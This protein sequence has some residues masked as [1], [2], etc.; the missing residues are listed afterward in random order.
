MISIMYFAGHFVPHDGLRVLS[1]FDF[2][3]FSDIVCL[4]KWKGEFACVFYGKDL[5]LPLFIAQY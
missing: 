2:N 4:Y 3:F 5:L 1:L